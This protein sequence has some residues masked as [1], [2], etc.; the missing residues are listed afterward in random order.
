MSVSQETLTKTPLK[1]SKIAL[2]GVVLRK[3]AYAVPLILVFLALFLVRT[4]FFNVA[5]GNF[6]MPFPITNPPQT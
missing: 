1:L 5:Y 6:T 2:I 3:N 4:P